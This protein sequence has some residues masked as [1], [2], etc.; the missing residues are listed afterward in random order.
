MAACVIL[1]VMNNDTQPDDSWLDAI[2]ARGLESAALTLLDV[3][4]PFAP[5]AAGLLR[6]LQP[7]SAWSGGSQWMGWLTATLEDPDEV[8]RL[9][10]ELEKSSNP[11]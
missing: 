5:L 8:T 10:K 1:T 2:R 7:V 3:V 6:V 9:R 11:P 4:E